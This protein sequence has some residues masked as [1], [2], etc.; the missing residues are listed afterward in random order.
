MNGSPIELNMEII[1]CIIHHYNFEFFPTELKTNLVFFYLF[2]YD[3]EKLV[4]LYLKTKIPEINVNTI[5][6]KIVFKYNLRNIY[7]LI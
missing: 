5:S 3:Y 1:E 2:R 7:N 6:N 4:K